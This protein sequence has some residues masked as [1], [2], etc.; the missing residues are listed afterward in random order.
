MTELFCFQ[1]FY[2]YYHMCKWG[3]FYN[4]WSYPPVVILQHLVVIIMRNYKKFLTS[5][6]LL[7]YI[8][9][10]TQVLE[11]YLRLMITSIMPH[12]QNR[13]LGAQ[14]TYWLRKC[15]PM[16]ACGIEALPTIILWWEFWIIADEITYPMNGG[17]LFCILCFYGGIVQLK[18]YWMHNVAIS[19]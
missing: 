13:S 5:H 14:F 4:L 19:H 3:T 12:L 6:V 16:I 11:I 10:K 15:T 7:R 2:T 8:M 1:C 18:L 9:S 17:G